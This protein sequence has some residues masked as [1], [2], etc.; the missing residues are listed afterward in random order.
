MVLQCSGL[1][2]YPG[3]PLL[4]HPAVG[5]GRDRVTYMYIRLELGSSNRAI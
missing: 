4:G 3:V 2:P 1:Q 5:S